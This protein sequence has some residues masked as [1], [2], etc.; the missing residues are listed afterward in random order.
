MGVN[1]ERGQIM[2][3]HPGSDAFG[4]GP[5]GPETFLGVMKSIKLRCCVLREPVPTG[6][7]FD[8]VQFEMV[9][10][11]YED[12][13]RRVVP[14]FEEMPRMRRKESIVRLEHIR[15]VAMSGLKGSLRASKMPRRTL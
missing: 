6:C 12:I 13:A 2:P 5:F 11:D 7:V 1:Q 4:N 15:S 9:S 10:S 14:V 3:I 8:S